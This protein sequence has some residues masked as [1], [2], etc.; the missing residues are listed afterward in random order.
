MYEII[1]NRIPL[2]LTFDIGIQASCVDWMSVLE[3]GNKRAA[4]V[5]SVDKYI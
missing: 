1:S 3:E 4:C 5:I 2:L